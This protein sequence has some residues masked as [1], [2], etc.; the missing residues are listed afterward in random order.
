MQ[1][2]GYS[3]IYLFADDTNIN[4]VFYNIA[5]KELDK[6]P[7]WFEANKHIL[8]F[9]KTCFMVF[10]KGTHFTGIEV[11]INNGHIERGYEPNSTDSRTQ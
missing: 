10:G 8:N 2:F 5:N 6:L 4:N 1:C 7:Y 9:S 11:F 3:G